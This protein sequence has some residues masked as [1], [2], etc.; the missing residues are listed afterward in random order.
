MTNTYDTSNE[1]LG[2]T[3][4]KVLYNNASNFDDA[5]NALASTWL[6]RF[7]R[8]RQ[9]WYG[10]EQ[11]FNQ[12]LINSGFEPNH[13]TYVDGS[14]LQVDRPTQLIDRSGSVYRV[15]MPSSFPVVLTGNWASDSSKLV[16][17]GD[18]SLRLQL[19]APTGSTMLGYDGGTATQTVKDRLGR[20]VMATD[21]PT[22]R[23]AANA[24]LNILVPP[25][26]YNVTTLITLRD[27]QTITFMPGAVLTQSATGNAGI[28]DFPAGVKNVLLQGPGALRGPAYGRTPAP[29]PVYP[30]SNGA[31]RMNGNLANPIL[32][33]TI[34]G[35]IIEG[36]DDYGIFS[37]QC[38][39]FQFD[40]NIIRD[41][42]RDGIRIYGN[43]D[44][45]TNFNRIS[46]IA[47]G[48]GGVAPN[49]NVYGITYTRRADPVS[50][51]T[52]TNPPPR[53][54]TAIGN[55]V[56]GCPTWKALDT[57]GGEDITFEA[58]VVRDAHIGIGIDEGDTVGFTDSPPRRIKVLGNDITRGSGNAGGA[59]INISSSGTSNMGE[60]CIL[61][62]NTVRGFGGVGTGGLNI[63]YQRNLQVNGGHLLSSIIA[64]INIPS[65]VRVT[66]LR[67]N[68]VT[69]KDTLAD[70][71]TPPLAAIA[72]QAVEASGTID[73]LTLVRESGVM[74]GL[75]LVTP[76]TGYGI[77]LGGEIDI[78]GTVTLYAANA[79]ARVVGGSAVTALK[80]YCRVTS[81]GV[82]S[83]SY[84]IASV[85]YV[86]AGVYDVVI[87][88]DGL[89]TSDMIVSATR[90]STSAG[91]IAAIPT[92]TN[93][94]RV[95]TWN[96]ANAPTDTEFNLT[97][98]GR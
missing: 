36:W 84:G 87:S 40:K 19:A 41:C 5:L 67:I 6:D 35:L 63:A 71:A 13:L 49:L 27:N 62:D 45:G 8:T 18:L 66:G 46:N 28:F 26:T 25:G 21:Y 51:P 22:I 30:Q 79:R 15:K 88:A 76:N 73:G 33:P 1:P 95:S 86:S 23:E 24:N 14:P 3:A 7:G 38:I 92:S 56:T 11:A 50:S 31:I 44:G 48:F 97:L 54:C 64:G 82:L 61:A 89:S 78:Q 65:G 90:R 75:S 53:R 91:G 10:F 70:G 74:T 81:G 20:V 80:A 72:V 2:S 68:D 47:P 77:K 16:D 96:S 85:T 34:N 94:I 69:I 59:G 39:N 57:H 9:S 29:S 52:V 42:G 37:E 43:S 93:T 12:F 98:H 55:I 83:N 32:N 60:D 4:V 58:N 17:V